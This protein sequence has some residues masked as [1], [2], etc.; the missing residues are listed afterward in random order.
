MRHNRFHLSIMVR[1]FCIELIARLRSKEVRLSLHAKDVSLERRC[2]VHWII[3]RVLACEHMCLEKY[4]KS[5][6]PHALVSSH[7][8]WNPDRVCLQPSIY[9]SKS[10]FIHRCMMMDWHFMRFACTAFFAAHHIDAILNECTYA[11]SMF[12]VHKIYYVTL[13]E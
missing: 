9:N 4:E 2:A 8:L 7:N 6:Q 1:F 13:Y 5:N 11:R 12:R 3:A 10:T